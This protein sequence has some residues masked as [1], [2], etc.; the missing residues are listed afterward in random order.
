[1]TLDILHFIDNKG[2]NAAEIK[3]SQRKRGGS[4]ELVDEIIAMYTEWVKSVSF[5]LLLLPCRLIHIFVVV[6]LLVFV[7]S[8]LGS[9]NKTKKLTTISP[10]KSS[11]LRYQHHAQ[12]SQRNSKTNIYQEKGGCVCVVIPC[13]ER[14]EN[15][16]EICYLRL[17]NQQMIW[18]WRKNK[19]TPQLKPRQKK[20]KSSKF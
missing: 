3:E 19:S 5:M 12:K 10:S 2:G 13:F 11:G 4:V 9:L 14:K 1:M 6:H 16:I 20:Q 7:V 17:K 18:S 15:V 8:K